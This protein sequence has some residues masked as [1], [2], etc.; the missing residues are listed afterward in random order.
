VYTYD[1]LGLQ[2]EG[3]SDSVTMR[4]KPLKKRRLLPRLGAGFSKVPPLEQPLEEY[5]RRALSVTPDD[6]KRDV[7]ERKT[8]ATKIRNQ[9]VEAYL[10][11]LKQ[12][13]Q[14]RTEEKEAD[15][16]HKEELESSD[17]DA[18]GFNLSFSPAIMAASRDGKLPFDR[19]GKINSD[20]RDSTLQSLRFDGTERGPAGAQGPTGYR[21]GLAG[22]EGRS[23]AFETAMTARTNRTAGGGGGRFDGGAGLGGRNFSGGFD[24]RGGGSGNKPASPR[25]SRASKPSPFGNG[26]GSPMRLP[27]PKPAKTEGDSVKPRRRKEVERNPIATYSQNIPHIARKIPVLPP[28]AHA[29]GGVIPGAKHSISAKHGATPRHHGAPVSPGGKSATPHDPLP[30][31]PH[32]IPR[33]PV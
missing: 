25:T 24:T 20:R 7:R 14:R 8:I 15:R 33:S 16:K 28:P 3:A 17:E 5:Q 21:R 10:F 1:D 19:I 31:S 29:V 2:P 12:L 13:A 23:G 22:A 18:G 9:E 11:R 32:A 4:Q 30:K 26:G 27:R 6:V